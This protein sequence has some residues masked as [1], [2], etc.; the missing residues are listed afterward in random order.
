MEEVFLH[1]FLYYMETKSI[2]L[3][4]GICTLCNHAVQFIIK[5][6]PDQK[7]VFASLQSEKGKVILN[8]HGFSSPNMKTFVLI[9]N[10]SVFTKSTAAL[11]IAKQLK[12]PI[13]F[14]YLFIIFTPFIRDSIYLII[15]NNRYRWFGK[16]NELFDTRPLN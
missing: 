4:D 9:E 7:F 16:K 14:V 2:I 12:G 10:G 6:D 5:H 8:K 11:K 15:S 1:F 13:Q 3:F